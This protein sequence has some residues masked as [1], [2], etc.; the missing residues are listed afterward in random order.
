MDTQMWVITHK[1]YDEPNDELYK[2]LHVG[3]AASDELGYCGD[4]TG[5]NI[6]HKNKNY[7]ELTGIYWIWKN[8]KCD[9]AGVCHYRRF[10]LENERFLTKQYIEDTLKEYDIIVPRSG[11]VES[12]TVRD[13]YEKEHYVSDFDVCRQVISEKYPSYVN[14]FDLMQYSKMMNF[15]N[16]FITRKDIFDKYCEWLFDILFEVEKRIDISDRDD[17]QKRVFGFLSERLFKVW[18]IRNSYKVKEQ[19]VKMM[20][21]DEIDRYFHKINLVKQL[22]EKLTIK[23]A[24]EYAKGSCAK[25]SDTGYKNSGKFPVWMCWWQGEE[26]APDIVKKCINSVRKHIDNTKCEL[27]IITFENWN[28]YV[29][30]SEPIIEKFNSG[31]ITMTTLSDR[32]RMELL[33]RYGGM[34]LDATYYITDDRI[35]N[36]L[37][38]DA[39]FTIKFKNA[40][41]D[42]D[43]TKG[44][45]SG[46]CLKGPAGFSLFGFVMEAFDEYYRYMDKLID[47]FMIDYFIAVAYENIPQVK[48]EIDACAASNPSALIF[49]NSDNCNKIYREQR[50]NEIRSET[51]I[52]K[53]NLKKSYRICNMAGETTYYGEIIQK[54]PF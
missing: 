37:S 45:W 53:F 9:I 50:W 47:Y 10:F 21:S 13:H 11:L 52:F 1:K 51:F 16:M 24:Y 18:L 6:S 12:C 49:N 5:D 42:D 27:H 19:L 44:R 26:N 28:K 39:F 30:F 41:W 46:N 33:Y 15:C 14:A 48:A 3:R 17:Y 54:A 29:T 34:W 31:K 43:V 36:I 8:V 23:K 25:L 20:D 2:T 7:C 35:Q 22:A 38:D 32:L 4:N 40:L